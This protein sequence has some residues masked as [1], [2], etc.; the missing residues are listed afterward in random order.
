M[1][2]VLPKCVSPV[3][4][5]RSEDATGQAPQQSTSPDSESLQDGAKHHMAPNISQTK[6]QSSEYINMFWT[7][8]PKAG[9]RWGGD[10]AD[11]HIFRDLDIYSG[12][13]IHLDKVL[14]KIWALQCLKHIMVTSSRPFT[15]RKWEKQWKTFQHTATSQSSIW[16]N[17][18]RLRVTLW[19]FCLHQLK[20]KAIIQSTSLLSKALITLSRAHTLVLFLH[21]CL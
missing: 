11:G 6:R 20:F 19:Y 16:L 21:F 9:K 13:G 2:L 15:R 3:H 5:A 7:W 8:S 12:L 14:A 17:S 1:L 10:A 18:Y 4:G